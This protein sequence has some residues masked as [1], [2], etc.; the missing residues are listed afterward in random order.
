MRV[1]AFDDI[2]RALAQG[3]EGAISRYLIGDGVLEPAFELCVRERIFT[4]LDGY[5]LSDVGGKQYGY[6]AISAFCDQRAC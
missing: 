1:P 4:A 3:Y 6:V 2:D 5:A